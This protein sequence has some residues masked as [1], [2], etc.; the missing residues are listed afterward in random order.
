MKKTYSR[1]RNL[2]IAILVAFCGVLAASM[3]VMADGNETL[4]LDTATLFRAARKV[5][6]V[7]QGLINDASKGDKGLSGDAVVE[8]AKKNYEAATG[9]ALEEHAADTLEGQA[10]QAM[11]DAI[12]EVMD[13][14]QPLINEEGKG[15][16]GF[17]PAVFA[18]Q[19]A[20][21]FSSNMAGKMFI[22]LTAPKKYVRNRRNRPDKWEHNIIEKKFKSAGWEKGKPFYEQGKRKGKKGFRLILPEYY[23]ASCLKCHGEPKGS[24]DVTGGKKEGGKL[25]ELG[26]AI[27]VVIYN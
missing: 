25:G 17:L 2:G 14:A 10:Q 6:S 20:T 26:G 22:K 5:V 4:A 23:G 21:S 8:M 24:L 3:P 19:L 11:F 12:H 9:G 15:F 7:N 27:S 1:K 13:A 16:K 18:G